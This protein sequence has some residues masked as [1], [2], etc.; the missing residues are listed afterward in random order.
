M[1]KDRFI[2]LASEFWKTELWEYLTDSD[3]FGI[4]LED[5]RIAYCC[6]M[7][8]SGI[9][10]GL[11]VFV[12]ERGFR[13]YLDTVTKDHADDRKVMFD[14]MASFDCMQMA[15]DVDGSIHWWSH[16]P[17][18]VPQPDVFTEEEKDIVRQVLSAC[19]SLRYL[20]DAKDGDV[21]S[22]GFDEYEEYPTKE[23]GKDAM[24]MTPEGSGYS[25]TIMQLPAYDKSYEE[26]LKQMADDV[27]GSGRLT[28]DLSLLQGL[29][30]AGTLQCRLIHPPT[31]IRDS[32]DSPGYYPLFLL[33]VNRGDGRIVQTEIVRFGDGQYVHTILANLCET[34]YR[35]GH[36]PLQISVPNEAT[37][38]L[39]KAF[40]RRQGIKL[41]L[42][43]LPLRELNEAWEGVFAY[44]DRD[45]DSGMLVN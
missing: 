26:E 7:G 30:K 12:G 37:E 21:V 36:Q 35:Q 1:A 20:I 8:N 15:F 40:C 13:T 33:T 29:R 38:G 4:T 5:G 27:V 2:E 42:E 32:D 17:H 28:A 19:I 39:L 43:R 22:L 41:V 31:P 34:M 45:G 24:L 9:H 16:H 11:G 18:Q 25:C 3:V 6:V 44:F 23:G 10:K 14:R